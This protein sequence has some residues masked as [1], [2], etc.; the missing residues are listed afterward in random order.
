ML[1]SSAVLDGHKIRE[2]YYN[3]IR[4]QMRETYKY[5]DDDELRFSEKICHFT[6]F[7]TFEIS[8][9]LLT[10]YF[11]IIFKVVGD[12]LTDIDSYRITFTGQIKDLLEIKSSKYFPNFYFLILSNFN[13]QAL[14][15]SRSGKRFCDVLKRFGN[16]PTMFSSSNNCADNSSKEVFEIE[17]T[18]YVLLKFSF[19][20]TSNGITFKVTANNNQNRSNR[21]Y[22][23]IKRGR[24][25]EMTEEKVDVTHEAAPEVNIV[26]NQVVTTSDDNTEGEI[27]V[28]KREKSDVKDKSNKLID[29]RTLA[30]ESK[31][32]DY[33]TDKKKS[34]I[35]DDMRY[36]SRTEKVYMSYSKDKYKERNKNVYDTESEEEEERPKSKKCSRSKLKDHKK[37]CVKKYREEEEYSVEEKFKSRRSSVGKTCNNK[38]KNSKKNKSKYETDYEEEEISREKSKF[39]RN[40][41]SKISNNRRVDDTEYYEDED[42]S[43][44]RIR[45]KGGNKYR[46]KD[47]VCKSK[48]KDYYKHK[49]DD[50]EKEARDSSDYESETSE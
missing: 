36:T 29:K 3:F 23:S 21:M 42:S 37:K 1:T 19:E 7:W 22:E 47:S 9:L 16:F 20:K 48:T 31:R 24:P 15:F 43:E 12:D 45:I 18:Q 17:F 40:V 27:P 34:Y 11:I 39:R 50:W 8:Y 38:N 35:K 32:K 30:N 4:L 6:E 44:E 13:S 2:I 28:V 10:K 33:K 14:T 41:Y 49:H 5:I 25:L 26:K 46:I